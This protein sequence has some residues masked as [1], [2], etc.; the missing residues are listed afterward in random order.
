MSQENLE[1]L[2]QSLDAW[3]RRDRATWLALSDPEREDLPSRAWPESDPVHGPEAIW[4]FYV[5]AWEPFDVGDIRMPELI[6]AGNDK[7]VANLRAE[8]R[9]KAS[10]VVVPWDLWQVVT[11]RKG[12]VLRIE[13]FVARNEAFEAVGLSA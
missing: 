4:D 7:V 2:Q 6:D 9:G 5:E 11:Y 3:N 1:L 10:G 12:K 13:W 8:V